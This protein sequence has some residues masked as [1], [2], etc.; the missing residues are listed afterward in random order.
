MKPLFIHALYF[1]LVA[2][3]FDTSGRLPSPSTAAFR[4]TPI[5]S[6]FNGT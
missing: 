1:A 6:K 5:A 4:P 3:Y 2:V